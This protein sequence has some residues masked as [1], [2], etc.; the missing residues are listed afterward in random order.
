MPLRRRKQKAP[1]EV[2]GYT[3]PKPLSS[4][5][6]A[7]LVVLGCLML[8]YAGSGI[9]MR[10]FGTE[11]TAAANTR[12]EDGEAVPVGDAMLSSTLYYTF[13]DADGVLREGHT[14]LL[15]NHE[16]IGTFVQIRYL[17]C[18]PGWTM[19]N[20]RAE[21]TA[22]QLGCLLL[23]VMLIGSGLSRLRQLRSEKES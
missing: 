5:S 19:L 1:R 15:G 23:G 7:V 12:L 13:R 18:A 4:F 8:L 10:L 22:V 3:P 9:T 16:P 21:Y 17:P 2:R 20:S 11:V 14:S 6:A